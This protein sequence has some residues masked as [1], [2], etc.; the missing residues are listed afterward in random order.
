M[1]EISNTS[2]S[3][4]NVFYLL[5]AGFLGYLARSG[6]KWVTLWL[7]RRKPAAEVH[8][9]AARTTEILVRSSSTAGDAVIRFMDRIETAQ[10]KIDNLIEERDALERHVGKQQ[11]ELEFMD[12][13][14]QKLNG[15]LKANGIK[16]SD[17]DRLNGK[18]TD[19]G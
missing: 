13:E 11:I 18:D 12:R 7:N 14:L 2:Q 6:Y 19:S 1:Q 4:A 3:W 17:Y 8:E 10:V 16:L 5:V 15:I 9:A